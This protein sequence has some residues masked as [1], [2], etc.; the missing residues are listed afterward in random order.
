MIAV[1]KRTGHSS[2]YVE[3]GMSAM[4]KTPKQMGIQGD[5]RINGGGAL[6]WLLNEGGSHFCFP[7]SAFP[8]WLEA[9]PKDTEFIVDF[10]ELTVFS[11]LECSVLSYCDSGRLLRFKCG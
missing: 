5:Y 10:Y 8:I 1:V 6:L 3:K 9:R 11:A 7:R 2:Y 4:G